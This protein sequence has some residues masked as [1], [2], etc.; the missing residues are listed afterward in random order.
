MGGAQF[1]EQA[2]AADAVCGLCELFEGQESS[3][4]QQECD[5]QIKAQEHDQCIG[6]EIGIVH[7]LF[8]CVP[9]SVGVVQP[10]REQFFQEPGG[11]RAVF[12]LHQQ[13]VH[14]FGKFLCDMVR[15]DQCSPV[16]ISHRG[17][18]PGLCEH[19]IG[20]TFQFNS[21]YGQGRAALQRCLHIFHGPLVIAVQQEFI[22]FQM[23]RLFSLHGQRAVKVG[24]GEDEHRGGGDRTVDR[25]QIQVLPFEQLSISQVSLSDAD[26]G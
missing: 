22:P 26:L 9:V 19:G 23:V 6:A 24:E 25:P 5:A 1:L 12:V 16:V 14:L 20:S 10:D 18:V 17:H 3:A 13:H 15:E 21:G 11:I 4:D 8:L 2:E 7:H